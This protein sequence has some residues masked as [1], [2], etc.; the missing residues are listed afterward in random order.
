MVDM[1]TMDVLATW[2]TDTSMQ[3]KGGQMQGR[4]GTKVFLYCLHPM[5]KCTGSSSHDQTSIGLGN[6]LY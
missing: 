4:I 5:H 3:C 1:E 6:V 2:T